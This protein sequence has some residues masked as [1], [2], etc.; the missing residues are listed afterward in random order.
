MELTQDPLETDP[1]CPLQFHRQ[2]ETASLDPTGFLERRRHS[3]TWIQS[4]QSHHV[5]SQL[6][7]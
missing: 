3:L 1:S 4:C 2:Q 6:S 5:K 7:G